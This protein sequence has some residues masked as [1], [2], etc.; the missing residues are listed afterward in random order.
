[1]VSKSKAKSGIEI[2]L[3]GLGW[4]SFEQM[5]QSLSIKILGPGVVVF[6]DGPDGGREATTNGKIPF[7]SSKNNWDGYAVIQ[8]KFKQRTEGTNADGK[9]ALDELRGELEKFSDPTKELT[10]PDYYIFATNVVL[11]PG[12]KK[13]AKDK[14][15]AL[16]KE[17]KS[18]LPIK[19]FRIWDFD[20]LNAFLKADQDVRNAFGGWIFSG[21]E[22]AKIL[23][24]VETNTQNFESIIASFLQKELQA[25]LHVN[26]EQAGHTSDE[27]TRL[28]PVFVDLPF[29][30]RPYIDPPDDDRVDGTPNG[31]VRHLMTAGSQKLDPRSLSISR[32]SPELNVS[33]KE[34]SRGKFVL[35][36]GPGQGKTTV[37]QFVA[38]LYR[39]SILKYRAK[40]SL[41]METKRALKEI[42]SQCQIEGIPMPL[43][44][45][46]PVRIV[47]K[48]Y[49]AKLAMADVPIGL[50]SYLAWRISEISE[51]DVTAADFRSWLAEY[52]WI[53][54]FDGLDEV[55][56]T[57]NRDAVLEA[58]DKFM[59]DVAEQ[60]ADV[61]VFAT[62]R[63]QG[64]SNEF[65][66]D[67]YNH[68]YLTPLRP[69]EALN[70]ARRLAGHHFGADKDR[71]DKIVGRL[72]RASQED[73]TS[74]L[75]RSP[76]Q[77]TI[78]STLVDQGGLP[79]QERWRLFQQY[80][81]VIYS[82][83]LSKDTSVSELLRDYQSD[84][85]VIHQQVGLTLQI[86][87]EEKGGTESNLSSSALNKIIEDRLVSEGHEGVELIT[88]KE[89]FVEASINRLV[90]LVGVTADSVGFEIR[91]LQEFMAGEALMAG[92][93]ELVRK[94]LEKISGI[95]SWVNVFLFAAG[96][97][98]VERQHLRDSI[99]TIC[100]AL[101]ESGDK[102]EHATLAGSR[103]ALEL[104]EDGSSRK[105]P[106]FSKMFA[107]VALK[108]LDLPPGEYHRRLAY[109]YDQTLQDVYAEE[110]EGKLNQARIYGKI[111]AWLTLI[112]ISSPL[113]NWVEQLAEK[114]W[115]N[116]TDELAQI[117]TNLNSNDC[118][119][120]I[121]KKFTEDISSIKFS[122]KLNNL[123]ISEFLT[124]G[125]IYPKETIEAISSLFEG[126]YKN[127]HNI[128]IPIL[129]SLS[130]GLRIRLI[131][132]DK[133]KANMMQSLGEIKE[134][135]NDWVP[136]VEAAKFL[137]DPN[138]HS[139]ST[140]LTN[141]AKNWN[142]SDSNLSTIY[143]LPW[144]L[145]MCIFVSL[146]NKELDQLAIRA[147]NGELGDYDDWMA[148][149]DRWVTLGITEN[150]I[151][152][153]PRIPYSSGI[154]TIGF[155]PV[156]SGAMYMHSDDYDSFYTCISNLMEENITTEIKTV[157][158]DL[159][160]FALIAGKGYVGNDINLD[161][162]EKS[163]SLG[164]DKYVCQIFRLDPSI[165]QDNR[166]EEMARIWGNRGEFRSPS[167]VE[168]GSIQILAALVDIFAKNPSDTGI[169]FLVS[170]GLQ[171]FDHKIPEF[172][173][174]GADISNYT[175]NKDRRSALLINIAQN[176]G[177]SKINPKKLAKMTV[178]LH[179]E[180]EFIDAVTDVIEIQSI[181]GDNI[182]AYLVS[183]LEE[184]GEIDIDSSSKIVNHLNYALQKRSSGL[185]N[186]A[187]RRELDLA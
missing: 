42:E 121:N 113:N 175:E 182:E 69:E 103:L 150:D 183:L 141:I 94:R 114:Y 6:G 116:R 71:Y 5:V 100:N 176:C 37:G 160:E 91:S 60:N 22:L 92:S 88:L 111:S 79:P 89:K 124:E 126:T 15:A 174:I 162:L 4:R 65:S 67:T 26:L 41:I 120:W 139:L 49:A 18:K 137:R 83:E 117:I 143:N 156:R 106:K 1:M 81:Q 101:N 147:A 125:G 11:S 110:I 12:S 38:Q 178:K 80:Y 118:P 181:V 109:V 47:L 55:P 62:T 179:T 10:C 74:R 187:T 136:I 30:D 39:A 173:A 167:I 168:A 122:K 63:P 172:S 99:Y 64:Y 180:C 107:R 98:F 155:P 75:M 58:V 145:S 157:L 186:M 31:F 48:D 185:A 177:W 153:H 16:F 138:K 25:D 35:I 9:W 148:A 57:S 29:R 95:S 66:P 51:Y 140:A 28:A 56:D 78:M 7:P 159:M 184:L 76:L 119:E 19:D 24:L 54:I 82:R 73:T 43:G 8:A 151:R 50:L 115:G 45:R 112:P 133:N 34:L 2:D 13:G 97:C 165:V 77:V 134:Y 135:S 14:A 102:I 170:L 61:L 27:K 40:S 36:G 32:G 154:R 3:F 90:F 166:F 142:K 23:G 20:Q 72:E 17:F 46:F 130:E 123:K 169:L 52:P 128:E 70:Y 132:V 68:L 84:I 152:D 59:I 158:A 144:V 127:A 108:L 44:K 105:Q 96:H 87:I 21:D 171:S 129:K 33:D 104:L 163:V 53:V 131:S 164:K 146:T 161:L 149:E 86:A 93:D 85:D